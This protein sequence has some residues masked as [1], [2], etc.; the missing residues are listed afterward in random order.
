M[1]FWKTDNHDPKSKSNPTQNTVDLWIF[2]LAYFKK[3]SLMVQFDV[4]L[5]IFE[6]QYTPKLKGTG[7]KTQWICGFL[8]GGLSIG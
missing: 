4:E 8:Y 1:D 7:C 6:N 5:W 2:I 3:E